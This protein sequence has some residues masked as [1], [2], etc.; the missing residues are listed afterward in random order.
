MAQVVI[1]L[2]SDWNGWVQTPVLPKK[3]KLHS[4]IDT[5]RKENTMEIIVWRETEIVRGLESMIDN[6]DDSEQ[7][8]IFQ[9]FKQWKR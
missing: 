6:V 1:C 7:N 2:P 8:E 3:F 5:Q 4:F 9:M